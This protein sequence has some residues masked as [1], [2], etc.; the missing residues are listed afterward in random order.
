LKKR[1]CKVCRRWFR[2]NPRV[3]DEQMT[4]GRPKCKREWHRKKCAEWN[5]K[6]R[7]YFKGIYLKNKILAASEDNEKPGNQQNVEGKTTR[8]RFNL[9]LPRQEI[10]E[11]MGVKQLIII[12]YIIHLLLRF[13]QEPIKAQAIV[14]TG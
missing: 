6:N 12:E 3:G 14:D 13:F 1:P 4:C 2:P 9:G 5:R 10:Q 11:V 7:E 8:T